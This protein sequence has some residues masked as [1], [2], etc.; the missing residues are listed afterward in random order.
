MLRPEAD[1][2]MGSYDERV[3]RPQ[4][5]P[6]DVEGILPADGSQRAAVYTYT[7]KQLRLLERSEP[8]TVALGPACSEVLTVSPA[9]EVWNAWACACFLQFGLC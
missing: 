9:T 4:V 5:K 8:L 6:S 1:I 3:L 2:V 7:T